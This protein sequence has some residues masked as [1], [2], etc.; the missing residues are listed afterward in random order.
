MHTLSAPPA[1]RHQLPSHL[2]AP[3]P[4]R[5]P[6]TPSPAVQLHPRTPAR[7]PWLAAG[8]LVC[9]RPYAV[10]HLHRA[11]L[12]T[13]QGDYYVGRFSTDA[14]AT[15][16]TPEELTIPARATITALLESPPACGFLPNPRPPGRH[17]AAHLSPAVPPSPP[18]PFAA[19]IFPPFP[20]T[21]PPNLYRPPNLSAVLAATPASEP[22]LLVRAR[23]PGVRSQ[24]L[25][26]PQPTPHPTFPPPNHH[27]QRPPPPR[28]ATPP[29]SPCP[30]ATNAIGRR[31]NHPRARLPLRVPHL[32]HRQ[33]HPTSRHHSATPAH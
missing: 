30:G 25:V 17:L 3:L 32:R 29:P 23:S 28:H 20:V 10:T 21:L 1:R 16:I 9:L 8:V 6:A 33:A 11:C 7:C 12:V 5:A 14:F 22:R 26:C 18:H 27:H 13:P 15:P 19:L 4:H 31:H 2:A 24:K